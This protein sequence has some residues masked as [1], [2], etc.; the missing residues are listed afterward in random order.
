ML[1]GKGCGDWEKVNDWTV[2]LPDIEKP[3]IEPPKPPPMGAPTKKIL[4]LSD[5]HLDLNYMIGA[6]AECDLPMCCSSTVGPAP[7]PESAAKYWGG[8]KCDLPTWTFKH[9]LEHIK[10][11]HDINYI[12]LTGKYLVS[13]INTAFFPML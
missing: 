13:Y 11:T 12:M 1:L 9:M 8:Y 7:N 2:D 6:N 10:E 4:H 3:P 5:L